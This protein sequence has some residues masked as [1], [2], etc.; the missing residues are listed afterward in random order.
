MLGISLLYYK[1]RGNALSA[2]LVGAIIPYNFVIYYI[3][4]ALYQQFAYMSLLPLILYLVSSFVEKTSVYKLISL[5][6]TVIIGWWLWPWGFIVTTWILLIPILLR[7]TKINIK[8]IFFCLATSLVLGHFI[9]QFNIYKVPFFEGLEAVSKTRPPYTFSI[10]LERA[11]NGSWM[12]LLFFCGGLLYNLVC[13]YHENVTSKIITLYTIGIILGIVAS[14]FVEAKYRLTP[15]IPSYWLIIDFIVYVF[16]QKIPVLNKKKI[17]FQFKF[18]KYRFYSST[19]FLFYVI[20]IILF[21]SG[22]T[23]LYFI[24]PST[25]QRHLWR[26]WLSVNDTSLISSLQSIKEK[27]SQEEMGENFIIIVPFNYKYKSVDEVM[28]LNLYVKSFFPNSIMIYYGERSWNVSILIK[29]LHMNDAYIHPWCAITMDGLTI[30]SFSVKGYQM[31]VL[32]LREIFYV[33]NLP[34][35]CIISLKKNGYGIIKL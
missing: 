25:V 14:P 17:K 15:F 30:D 29:Y 12:L 24:E 19:K 18:F 4:S 31:V 32:I 27:I 23:Q 11:F 35:D 33:D 7:D 26:R 13:L 9:W 22:F 20:A 34:L 28:L 6:I 8:I 2:G 21:L 5:I 1:A 10:F 16:L 3:F